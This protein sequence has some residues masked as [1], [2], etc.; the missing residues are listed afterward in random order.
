MLRYLHEKYI[1]IYQSA[2][3][4]TDDMEQ[5]CTGGCTL[6]QNILLYL[7]PYQ[8]EFSILYWVKTNLNIFCSN[9]NNIYNNDVVLKIDKYRRHRNPRSG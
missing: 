3:S 8:I 6:I 5:I 2:A 9:K 1:Y 7:A 4:S